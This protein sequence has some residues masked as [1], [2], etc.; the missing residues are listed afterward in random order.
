M[1]NDSTCTVGVYDGD[2]SL[3]SVD[4]IRQRL[5]SVAHDAAGRVEVGKETV[6]VGIRILGVDDR[7]GRREVRRF[8]Y[9][10]APDV[11]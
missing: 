4:V 6:C 3:S 2:E 8:P 11:I 9:Q 10:R 1:D 5:S 7:D